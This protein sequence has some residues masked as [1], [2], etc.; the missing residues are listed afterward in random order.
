MWDDGL[1]H[2]S[3]ADLAKG[4]LDEA[5]MEAVGE[6][7]ASHETVEGRIVADV[8]YFVTDALAGIG[9]ALLAIAEKLGAPPREVRPHNPLGP[10]GEPSRW[11]PPSTD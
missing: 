5:V 1:D 8:A 4:Y 10:L 3:Y 9:Y 6:A 2:R 11:D 7:R